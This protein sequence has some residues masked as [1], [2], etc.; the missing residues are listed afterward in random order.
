MKDSVTVGGRSYR[1]GFTTGSCAAAAAKAAVL[2]LVTGEKP[3]SVSIHT[4]AGVELELPVC[5]VRLGT[6]RCSCGVV[7]DGGDDPDVTTGLTITAEAVFTGGT[8][9]T[10]EGGEGVGRVTKPGLKVPVGRPAINPAPM[11]MIRS[12]VRGVTGRGVRITVSVPGGVT[13]AERTY[14]PRL[15]IEGGIS[16]LGTSGLVIPMSEEAWKDAITAELSVL[17]ASGR[18]RTVFVFGGY[19]EAFIRKRFA[20]AKESSIVVSN[21]V[22]RML[23][24]AVALGMEEIVLAGHMG[25]LVK[26]SGGSFHTH[27]RVSDARLETVC[28]FAGL[29]GASTAVLQELYRCVT[30]DA[31]VEILK[32]EHLDSVFETIAVRAE[33]RCALYVYN[34]LKVGA[35]LFHGADS[36]L[37]MTG[38]AA[39]I[40]ARIEEGDNE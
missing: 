18:R 2:A 32:R 15:G 37:Y 16:I 23:E 39:E 11:E 4:P 36:L 26:V 8:G 40:L 19:G 7:K 35:V 6:D 5:D 13:A 14:N 25:K 22:G 28:A 38:S 30:T 21:F 1:K 33:E 9:I 3:S 31:A 20:V 24:E 10:I 34:R 29:A 12:E 27:S 17:Y